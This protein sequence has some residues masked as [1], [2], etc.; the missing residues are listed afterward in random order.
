MD[1]GEINI[2][3]GFPKQPWSVVI[4]GWNLGQSPG[5]ALTCRT[6]DSSTEGLR[7]AH[8]VWEADLAGASLHSSV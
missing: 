8:S 2:R 5:S 7:G 6:T 3:L 1:S 4:P